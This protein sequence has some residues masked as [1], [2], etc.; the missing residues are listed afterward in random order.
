MVAFW[1]IAKD[2]QRTMFKAI[3]FKHPLYAGLYCIYSY[4]HSWQELESPIPSKAGNVETNLSEN[5]QEVWLRLIEQSCL[6]HMAVWFE[7]FADAEW[8][9]SKKMLICQEWKIV[10]ILLALGNG[11]QYMTM[12]EFENSRLVFHG[13]TLYIYYYIILNK[14]VF[15]LLQKKDSQWTWINGD[16][17]FEIIEA[18]RFHNWSAF[19]FLGQLSS[20]RRETKLFNS[21]IWIWSNTS[22]FKLNRICYQG[23]WC[24][25]ASSCFFWG[26]H[27]VASLLTHVYKCMQIPLFYLSHYAVQ[28]LWFVRL[29]GIFIGFCMYLY[30][31]W[32]PLVPLVPD[33][34]LGFY[35][36]DTEGKILW[37]RW[38]CK[39]YWHSIWRIRRE[40][41][42]GFLALRIPEVCLCKS[43][44][45]RKNSL[46][47]ERMV[48]VTNN[49]F[50]K[51]SS[52][53]FSILNFRGVWGFV[54]SRTGGAL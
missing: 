30:I 19:C 21:R 11:V 31:H 48:H 1:C 38:T 5:V 50:S 18:P 8:G 37:P 24:S 51:E 14:N 29:I 44:F 22:R 17:A 43:R 54:T 15:L 2:S 4:M 52:D 34:P 47:V 20:I 3:L 32:H 45:W 25:L 16:S 7:M 10:N 28:L 42:W 53:S 33:R 40:V 9:K 41:G 36:G 39:R 27:S 6:F 23:F 49:G 46:K 26:G 35:P 12:L 13:T